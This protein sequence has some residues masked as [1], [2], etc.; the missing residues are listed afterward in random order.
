[1]RHPAPRELF[2]PQFLCRNSFT[3]DTLQ[4]KVLREYTGARKRNF[5]R[6]ASSGG[7]QISIG[8]PARE[9]S[10]E[11]SSPPLNRASQTLTWASLQALAIEESSRALETRVL[12]PAAS[13]TDPEPIAAV[14]DEHISAK[15][16]R[17]I[18]TRRVPS[19]HF[20]PCH[21]VERNNMMTHTF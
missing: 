6:N 12:A 18:G 21:K 16:E 9:W 17:F 1:M 15:Q 20:P 2:H 10:G 11:K 8:R 7:P 13:K 19:P 3:V 5:W 14:F 4:K